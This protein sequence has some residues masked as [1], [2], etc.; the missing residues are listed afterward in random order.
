MVHIIW[1]II[2]FKHVVNGAYENTSIE[3]ILHIKWVSIALTISFW[4]SSE[5]Y[6]WFAKKKKKIT[7]YLN[8]SRKP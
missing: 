2:F 1:Y 4:L 3:K 8:L 5:R 6:P 7:N